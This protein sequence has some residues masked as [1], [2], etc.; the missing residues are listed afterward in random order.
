MI[1]TG[2]IQRVKS[3]T[4]SPEFLY[5]KNRISERIWDHKIV[6]KVPQTGAGMDHVRQKKLVWLPYWVMYGKRGHIAFV[7]PN[8]MTTEDN[9][10][11]VCDGRQNHHT[12]HAI[13][14]LV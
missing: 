10:S 12:V 11:S 14:Y 9:S 6:T 7:C 4:K 2:G 1:Q 5:G 13:E 3:A 8:T